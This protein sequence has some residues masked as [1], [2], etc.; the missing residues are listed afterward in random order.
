MEYAYDAETDSYAVVGAGAISGASA[1]FLPAYYD[2]KPVTQIGKQAFDRRRDWKSAVLPSSIR[3]IGDAAFRNCRTLE[4][5]NIPSCVDSIGVAAF[6]GC[7]ELKEMRIPA[8]VTSIGSSAFSG[9][10]ALEHIE[11]AEENPVYRGEGNCII[12]RSTGRLVVG[13]KNSRIPQGVV[14]IGRSAFYG[15]GGLKSIEL[16]EGVA[17]IGMWAFA[18]CRELTSVTIPASVT[19]MEIAAFWGDIALVAIRYD[20]TMSAWKAIKKQ[21]YWDQHLKNYAVYCTDGTVDKD[22]TEHRN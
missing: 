7:F 15:H 22:G 12:E 20:G 9:C 8:S 21:E 3:S 2:G 6:N 10:S 4:R 18:E 17:E 5:I 19:F 14:S 13:C 1:L 16:P 11:V